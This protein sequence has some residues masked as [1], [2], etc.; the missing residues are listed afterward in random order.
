MDIQKRKFI[1]IFSECWDFLYSYFR[2]LKAWQ[3]PFN[4]GHQATGNKIFGGMF[5]QSVKRL[6]FL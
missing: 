3:I 2:S 5:K 1:V 6:D 4:A